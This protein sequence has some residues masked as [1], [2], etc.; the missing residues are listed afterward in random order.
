MS[1]RYE[2]SRWVDYPASTGIKEE[3]VDIIAATGMS[4]TGRAQNIVLKREYTGKDTL[5]FDI[6]VKYIDS[7]TGEWVVNPLC[8]KIIE[9]TK[10]KLWRDERWYNHFTK[11]W[12]QGRWY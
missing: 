7:L 4:F 2:M 3:K 12:Q 6:P 10:I 8:K 5:E 9:K 11:E 1:I